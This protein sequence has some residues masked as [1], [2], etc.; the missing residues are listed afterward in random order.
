M[1][2]LT[3]GAGRR[4][5]QEY[6]TDSAAHQEAYSIE[7]NVRSAR[8]S[9]QMHVTD[10]AKALH[11]DSEIEAAMDWCCLDK[12]KSEPWTEQL[13]RLKSRL[14]SKKNTPEGRSI[15]WNADKLSLSGGLLYYRYKPEY[16]IEEVKCFVVP[17]AHRTAIDGC[18]CDTGHQ[19]KKRTASL[20]S[21]QFWWPGVYEDVNRV[22]QNCRWCQTYGGREEKAHMV[23]MMVTASLQLVHLNF[24]SFETTIN[25]NE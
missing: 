22:V 16:Q 20:I 15:L 25:L 5:E 1:I 23:L 12:K 3:S 14:G 8:L 7:V 11:E 4:A 10:W 18:H 2:N 24:T 6:N 9:T 19:G 13:V 17:Q 21:D